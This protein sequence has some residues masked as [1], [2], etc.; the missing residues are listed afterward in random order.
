MCVP[1]VLEPLSAQ[2]GQVWLLLVLQV[3]AVDDAYMV[4]FLC[5]MCEEAGKSCSNQP[6]S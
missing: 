2:S 6:S 5:V 3:T 4:I 1:E